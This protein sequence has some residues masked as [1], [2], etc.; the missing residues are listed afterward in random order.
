MLIICWRERRRTG[1][2]ERSWSMGALAAQFLDFLRFLSISRKSR[3]NCRRRSLDPWM[4]WWVTD[5]VA[6]HLWAKEP[7]WITCFRRLPQSQHWQTPLKQNISLLAMSANSTAEFHAFESGFAHLWKA[8]FE[9]VQSR[10][11][12]NVGALYI[13]YELSE[14]L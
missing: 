5:P 12:F 7:L 14:Y 3:F 9:E 13:N 6:E 4:V 10:I 1:I 2:V 11:P 8:A